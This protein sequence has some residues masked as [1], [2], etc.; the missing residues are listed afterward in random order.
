MSCVTRRSGQSSISPLVPIPVDG[1]FDRV[2]VD[3]IKFLKSKR[4]NS[5]AV[6]FIDY[7]TKWFEVFATPDLSALAIARLLVG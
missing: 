1:P 6:C 2:G 3:I 5:Y 7:L 4:G